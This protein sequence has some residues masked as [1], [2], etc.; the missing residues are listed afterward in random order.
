MRSSASAPAA[1][2][3]RENGFLP[4]PE[5]EDHPST[6]DVAHVDPHPP[7]DVAHDVS[8]SDRPKRSTN[9]VK[10]GARGLLPS[11]H[12]TEGVLPRG[13]V[14]LLREETDNLTNP[15]Q[16]LSVPPN[17]QNLCSL[18]EREALPPDFSSNLHISMF[19]GVAV[20]EG[21]QNFTLG[22]GSFGSVQKVKLS[23]RAGTTEGGE[24]GG[25]FSSLGAGG[26]SGGGS[27][28]SSSEIFALKVIPSADTSH[29]NLSAQV[30]REIRAQT[31]LVHPNIL[32]LH[33]NFRDSANIYLLL[34]Y[35]PN[36]EL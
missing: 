4:A 16:Q 34:E 19:E 31:G 14:L 21:G 6:D 17:P 29:S 8:S 5:S 28:S 22:K 36:G 15:P 35:C 7:Y 10:T 18:S 27:S 24:Q 33:A 9:D 1:E 12:E 26:D 32:R 3:N 25:P 20:E 11:P 30:E 23:R 2:Q 13:R